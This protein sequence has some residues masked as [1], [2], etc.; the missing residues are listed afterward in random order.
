[1]SSYLDIFKASACCKV[2]EY[3]GNYLKYFLGYCCPHACHAD[4]A[5]DRPRVPPN[6]PQS[7]PDDLAG[8]ASRHDLNTLIA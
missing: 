5:L 6:V 8:I 3:L 2:L 1:M 4:R 7:K